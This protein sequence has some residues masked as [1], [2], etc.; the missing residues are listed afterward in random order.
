MADVSTCLYLHVD[1]YTRAHVYGHMQT[2]A[3]VGTLLHSNKT[4]APSGHRRHLVPPG[5][6]IFTYIVRRNPLLEHPVELSRG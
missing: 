2:S 5:A 6:H 1:L 3:P 4:N